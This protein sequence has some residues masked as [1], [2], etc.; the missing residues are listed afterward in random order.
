MPRVE[1][2]CEQCGT[3]SAT[4][5]EADVAISHLACPHCGHAVLEAATQPSGGDPK[6]L[7]YRKDD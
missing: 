1:V 3:K 6:D 7:T 4:L 2:V 5:V